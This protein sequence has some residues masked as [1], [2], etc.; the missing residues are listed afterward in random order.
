MIDFTNF[1]LVEVYSEVHVKFLLQFL[2]T[3]MS[4]MSLL[5]FIA[6]I[7]RTGTMAL[8]G[9]FTVKGKRETKAKVLLHGDHSGFCC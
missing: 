3:R 1:G 6:T 7:T 9:R 8:Q 5:I 4:A 2:N